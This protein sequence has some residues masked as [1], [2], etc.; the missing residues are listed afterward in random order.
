MFVCA[1]FGISQLNIV[2]AQSIYKEMN[3]PT[4][5]F[6]ADGVDNQSITKLIMSP[7]KLNYGSS[8]N[9]SNEDY[10]KEIIY[11]FN[12]FGM[13]N[14][15]PA[16][17]IYP[18][19]GEI[20]QT[21]S[22]WLLK[23]FNNNLNTGVLLT[24]LVYTDTFNIDNFIN[25]IVQLKNTVLEDYIRYTNI[26][27]VELRDLS[28]EVQ[29]QDSLVDFAPKLNNLELNNAFADTDFLTKEIP[30]LTL[31]P[32]ELN[33]SGDQEKIINAEVTIQNNSPIGYYIGSANSFT[34]RSVEDTSQFFIN[35]SWATP[36]TLQIVDNA[37][38]EASGSYLVD[39]ELQAP[40]EP[41]NYTEIFEFIN[42]EEVVTEI[43]INLESEDTGLDIL[44]INP[45]GLGFLNVREE[46]NA[47]SPRLG[48]VLVGEVFKYTDEENGFYRIEYSEETYGWVSGQYITVI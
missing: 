30:N 3:I 28:I 34:L 32:S 45:T 29:E 25:N 5:F 17:I 4:E 26:T 36:K 39:L 24:L 37:F 18:E 12:K 23:Q 48:D 21:N 40:L 47:G 43:E 2:K 10:T 14:P 16:Y 33:L 1:G 46:P 22:D 9:F 19:A 6:V 8:V 41:G 15:P 20:Y 44:R 11:F 42:N 13:Q 27:E 38:I 35:D 31:T 7:V